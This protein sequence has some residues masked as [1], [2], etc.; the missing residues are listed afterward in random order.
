L[1]NLETR[2]K[3][4]PADPETIKEVMIESL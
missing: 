3:T 2:S 4:V 1:E